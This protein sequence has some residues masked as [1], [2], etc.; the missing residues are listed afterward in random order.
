MLD[1][2]APVSRCLCELPELIVARAHPWVHFNPHFEASS[3]FVPLVSPK[4][5]PLELFSSE[6]SHLH[7][8]P[9]S[10][11]SSSMRACSSL[12]LPS[13]E[14]R[15]PSSTACHV[16]GC[17]Q[18]VTQTQRS[19]DSRSPTRTNHQW[20]SALKSKH[21]TEGYLCPRACHAKGCG[22]SRGEALTDW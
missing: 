4:P 17:V 8:T 15:H 22:V 21:T 14:C 19:E 1:G 13:S 11:S 3:I 16:V 12:S 5:H 7:S 18:H 6:A 2:L 10:D 20:S 9:P